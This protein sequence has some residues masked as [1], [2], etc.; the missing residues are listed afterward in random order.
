V[1]TK[2][3]EVNRK[4]YEKIRRKDYD[5]MNEYL[6]SIYKKG[7]E[8]GVSSV[9]RVDLYGIGKILIDIKG[10]GAKT[11]SDIVEDLK[12]EMKCEDN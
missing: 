1:I 6:K 10:L 12:K 11:V 3:I 7:F 9:P 4:E 8:D 5:Q 2:N